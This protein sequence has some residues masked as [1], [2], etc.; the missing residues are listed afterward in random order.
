MT[1]HLH[2]HSDDQACGTMVQQI[3][4]SDKPC[5][6]SGVLISSLPTVCIE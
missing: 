3:S 4:Q 1:A 2:H 5:C 6:A